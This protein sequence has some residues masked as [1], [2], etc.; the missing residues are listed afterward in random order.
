MRVSL[1][2]MMI[3]AALPAAAQRRRAVGPGVVEREQRILFI[4]NSL[5]EFNGLPAMLCRLAAAGGH[6]AVCDAVTAGGY[7][8]EDHFADGRARQRL[9]EERWSIVVLQQGPSALDSSRINLREWT[10]QFAPLISAAGAR[11]ALYAVWPEKARSFDFPRVSDSYRLAASDVGGLF[12][13]AGDA[14]QAAWRRDPRLPLYASDDFH[15]SAAGSYLAALVIYRVIWGELPPLFAD[16]RFAAG[17][18]GRDLG[19]DD[20]RM[21]YLT[22][23]AEEV[24]AGGLNSGLM[25]F[26]NDP[27]MTQPERVS[28]LFTRRRFSGGRSG[29]SRASIA[30]V[31]GSSANAVRIAA[32]TSSNGAVDCTWMRSDAGPCTTW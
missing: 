18:A 3:L 17:V 26:S 8:L 11:P 5:T 2:V 19:L 27:A 20:S 4:G 22:A 31:S 12:F 13:P 9:A 23:S 21:T 10:A 29:S 24:A 30:S 6:H 15:P 28:P 32:A 7:A 25:S 16:R 1:A 14:W